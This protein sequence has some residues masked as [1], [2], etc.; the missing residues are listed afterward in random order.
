MS[1]LGALLRLLES[2]SPPRLPVRLWVEQLGADGVGRFCRG[3]ILVERGRAA[4]WPCGGG[5]ACARRIVENPLSETHPL[6]AVCESEDGYYCDSIPL[7]EAEAKELALSL[8]EVIRQLRRAMGI[9]GMVDGG[10]ADFPE[11]RGIGQL[12]GRRVLLALQPGLPGFEAWL[13]SLKAAVVLIPTGRSLSLGLRQRFG[14]G[15][16]VEIRVI[17]EI[18][19][20][21]GHQWVLATTAAPEAVLDGTRP[22]RPVEPAVC[23]AVDQDGRRELNPAEYG[24]IIAECS[25]LD[26][27]VDT[28]FAGEAGKC[29]GSRRLPDGRA[30][31][32][33]L[34]KHEA[35]VIVELVTTKRALRAGDFQT[36][37]V[38]AVERSV[39]RA[40]KKLDVRLGRYEWRAIHTLP[41]PTPEAKR[42]QFKPTEVLRWCVIQPLEHR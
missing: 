42:W 23:V 18:V 22:L 2:P 30:E 13:G 38:N 29:R 32:V 3:G 20:L 39:E 8:D 6:I 16:A 24:A 25:S 36:T 11:A 1:P 17:D 31:P 7:T 21:S 37:T 35:A 5:G 40:R 28:T 10:E 26:L 41:G 12:A 15:S 4:Y 27:F 34:T 14:A 9:V 33:A 19:E